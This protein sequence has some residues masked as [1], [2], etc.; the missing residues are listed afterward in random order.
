MP[1]FSGNC[2][3][4][5]SG[6]ERRA[7]KPLKKGRQLCNLPAFCVKTS[8]LNT[9][10]TRQIRCGLLSLYNFELFA[11]VCL[12]KHSSLISETSG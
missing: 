6:T 9:V 3:A 12:L 2:G 1:F 5:S 10:N 8:I 4:D 11:V 7:I